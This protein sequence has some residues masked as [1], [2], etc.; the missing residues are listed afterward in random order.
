MRLVPPACAG[1]HASTEPQAVARPWLT[2]QRGNSHPPAGITAGGHRRVQGCRAWEPTY[3]PATLAGDRCF[4]RDHQHASCC[5]RPTGHPAADV[6]G[7]TSRGRLAFDQ[8]MRGV[9]REL[10]SAHGANEAPVA[11]DRRSLPTPVGASGGRN[12]PR[13][14]GARSTVAG[15]PLPNPTHE[16]GLSPSCTLSSPLAAGVGPPATPGIAPGGSRVRNTPNGRAAR[17]GVLQK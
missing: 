12:P 14:E 16:Q 13:V 8:G 6:E 17:E 3:T 15:R 1:V 11:Q 4:G 9:S 5:R 10:R 7:T 2:S